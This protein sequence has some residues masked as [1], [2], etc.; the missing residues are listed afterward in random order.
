MFEIKVSSYNESKDL[1]AQGWPTKIIGVIGDKDLLIQGPHHLHVIFDDI[2]RPVLG[3]IHPTEDHFAEILAFSREFTDDD[4]VLVHCHFGISRST[5]IA[6]AILIQHGMTYLDAY[7]HIEMLRPILSPNK[8]IIH[9]IDRRFG[10]DGKLSEIVN[11]N[12]KYPNLFYRQI[13]TQG[14]KA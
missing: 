7:Y 10:L 12:E 13:L 8:L 2:A 14:D 6:I 11:Q 5:A 4:R 9:Y 3:Y 1:I